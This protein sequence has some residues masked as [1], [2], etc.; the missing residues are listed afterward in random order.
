MAGKK[1]VKP[2]C[3]R[4]NVHYPASLSS[5]NKNCLIAKD[6][7]TYASFIEPSRG[8]LRQVNIKQALWQCYMHFFFLP[9]NFKQ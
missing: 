4:A 5:F 1:N 3:V 7:L 6:S 8:I 9:V 2:G